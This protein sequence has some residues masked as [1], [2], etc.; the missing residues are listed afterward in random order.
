M[1]LFIYFEPHYVIVNDTL[2]G[3]G[4]INRRRAEVWDLSGVV[5]R[6]AEST[7]SAHVLS[8]VY[9]ALAEQEPLAKVPRLSR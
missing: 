7:L 2:M 5:P 8:G 9:T 3:H 6:S 1:E 4:D